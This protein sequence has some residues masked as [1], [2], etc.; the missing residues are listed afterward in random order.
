MR[1][2]R[3]SWVKLALWVACVTGVA[4][5]VAMHHST[6]VRGVLASWARIPCGALCGAL[7]LIEI[8]V[9]CEATRLWALLPSRSGVPWTTVFQAFARGE[10]VNVLAPA[11]SGDIVKVA[12][13][14]GGDGRRP[15]SVPQVMGALLAE[16]VLDTMFFLLLVLGTGVLLRR[17]VLHVGHGRG[18]LEHPQI[19]AA[20]VA[21]AAAAVGVI[22]SR[23]P[24]WL[25]SARAF[26]RE[27][28]GGLSSLRRVSQVTLAGAPAAG[29]WAAEVGALHLLCVTLDFRLSL[30]ATLAALVILN[31]GIALPVLVANLGTYEASLA[32]GLTHFG[33]PTEAAIAIATVHHALQVVAI[34]A[35]V[36]LAELALRWERPPH[37]S[38]APGSATRSGS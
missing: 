25:A 13:L 17:G 12:R 1:S 15:L 9:L 16:R 24:Q 11:R 4:A 33:V 30:L 10:A 29:A 5:Y 20:L 18:P 19:P 3:L 2:D 27:A 14:R 31:I 26:V 8:Q 6:Q 21:G 23:K 34:V 22:R 32:L 37:A 38:V 7:V 36:G 35:S 28:A